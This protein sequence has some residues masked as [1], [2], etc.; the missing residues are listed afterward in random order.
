MEAAQQEQS[1]GV[2]TSATEPAAAK[3][4]RAPRKDKGQARAPK[5]VADELRA[6]S[7]DELATDVDAAD[8]RAAAGRV[9]MQRRIDVMA[10]RMAKRGGGN[11]PAS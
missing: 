11:A 10:E 4:A 9:E 8:E 3:K 7:D 1:N 2:A 5:T 6:L